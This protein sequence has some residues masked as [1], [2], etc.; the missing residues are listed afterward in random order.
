MQRVWSTSWTQINIL[1]VYHTENWLLN[2]STVTTVPVHAVL[3]SPFRGH[4]PRRQFA[5]SDP[6]VS[7]VL[8]LYDECDSRGVYHKTFNNLELLTSSKSHQT[9]FVE[10]TCV[11]LWLPINKPVR[12]S[13]DSLLAFLTKHCWSGASFMKTGT[14][15]HLYYSSERPL[16]S[17]HNFHIYK[18][19]WVKFGK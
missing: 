5:T 3:P 19:I 11:S 8:T 18:P 16:T 2:M 12:F 9:P 7:L 14:V 15:T 6:R 17:T 4:A 10:T 13:Q 1:S